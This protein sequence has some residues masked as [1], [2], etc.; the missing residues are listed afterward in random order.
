[1]E[2]NMNNV[3]AYIKTAIMPRLQKKYGDELKAE[4]I[5]NHNEVIVKLVFD[6]GFEN[7]P[8]SRVLGAN[9]SVIIDA[10]AKSLTSKTGLTVNPCGSGLRFSA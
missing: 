8:F 1:M 5:C 10:I 9:G 3:V 4:L 2:K 6:I 7:V